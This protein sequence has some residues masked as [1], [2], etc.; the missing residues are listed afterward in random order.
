[1]IFIGYSKKKTKKQNPQK[2]PQKQNKT[3]QKT[4]NVE[5]IAF[6]SVLR[7]IAVPSGEL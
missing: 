2:T 1:M 3:K 6:M 5:N 7:I 4:E